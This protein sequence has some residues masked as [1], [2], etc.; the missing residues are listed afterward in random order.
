[1]TSE[2]SGTYECGT[3]KTLRAVHTADGEGGLIV[4][5]TDERGVTREA[6]AKSKQHAHTIHR[7]AAGSIFAGA[8]MEGLDMVA[9]A[10]MCDPDVEDV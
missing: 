10:N 5:L 6:K 8:K 7:V 9:L 3:N 1:M 2:K 4:R